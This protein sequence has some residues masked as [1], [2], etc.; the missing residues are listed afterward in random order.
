[1]IALMLTIHIIALTTS[2]LATT[3]MM[4]TTLQSRTVP[5]L[6]QRANLF[7][8]GIGIALGGILLINHPVGSRCVEL[9]AYLI[10]FVLAYR[11]I[12][13]RSTQLTTPISDGILSR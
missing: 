2:L 11:F 10:I 5:K 1:M 6:T 7:V 8:T 9:T 3:I 12:A 4:I 13:A